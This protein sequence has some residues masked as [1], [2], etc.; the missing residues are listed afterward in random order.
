M[1]EKELALK[2]I[3]ETSSAPEEAEALMQNIMAQCKALVEKKK[4]LVDDMLSSEDRFYEVIACII[5]E[6][7]DTGIFDPIDN[8]VILAV[9]R[10]ALKPIKAY[11]K[12]KAFVDGLNA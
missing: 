11:E 12:I 10:G 3:E 5:D 1:T 8:V 7:W 4:S 9:V 6:K 2:I